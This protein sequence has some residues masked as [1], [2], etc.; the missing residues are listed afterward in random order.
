M[1][2]AQETVNK[3]AKDLQAIYDSA[4]DLTTS[5]PHSGKL[6]EVADLKVGN[7]VN[8]G[9]PI[10]TLVNDTKL[11]LSLYYNYTYENEISV[12]PGR[13]GLHPLPSCLR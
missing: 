7:T 4:K 6:M 9:D 2:A 1:T 11:R 5:A 13:A 10:A 12:G 3:C 8:A